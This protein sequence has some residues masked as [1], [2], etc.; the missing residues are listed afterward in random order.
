MPQAAGG[1]PGVLP[2]VQQG[3]VFA[4]VV[5]G[6]PQASGQ[7]LKRQVLAMVDTGSTLS[8][9]NSLILQSV[10]APIIGQTTITTPD[11]ATTSVNT[12]QASLQLPNGFPLSDHL[13]GIIGDNIQG[14]I[15]C[16]VGRDI[17]SLYS[18]LYQGPQGKWQLDTTTPVPSGSKPPWW[19]WLAVG[20]SATG[21]GLGIAT[22]AM[23]E[24]EERQIKRL[25]RRNG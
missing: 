25:I 18:F 13:P 24:K 20:L 14:G 15:Q 11:G 23:V 17:L 21:V 10:G 19:T 5:V 12:F 3:P 6:P 16:L 1:S 8:S 4:V 7:P 22:A 9:V 2:L